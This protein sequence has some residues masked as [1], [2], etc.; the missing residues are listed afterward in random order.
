M[1]QKIYDKQDGF[2]TFYSV[3][4]IYLLWKVFSKET[5]HQKKI[6]TS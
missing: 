5:V 1:K 2:K 4:L 3:Q 6:D